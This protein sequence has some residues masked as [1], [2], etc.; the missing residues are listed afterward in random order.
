MP[1]KMLPA[2]RPPPPP[3]PS[4]AEFV[5]RRLCDQ[6]AGWKEAERR[7]FDHGSERV[8]WAVIFL[9]YAHGYGAVPGTRI[10]RA[11]GGLLGGL[12]IRCYRFRRPARSS[13][14]EAA[15]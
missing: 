5:C 13:P 10:A 12:L 3:T 2:R 9:G 1:P 4:A 6:S 14:V 8:F 7:N 11:I 15:G